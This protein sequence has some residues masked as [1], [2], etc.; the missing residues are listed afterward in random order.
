MN[1][2]IVRRFIISGKVQGVF[3][4]ASTRQQALSLNITGYARNLSNGGVEVF[5]A[6][7]EQAVARLHQ[8]LLQGPP[9]ARVDRVEVTEAFTETDVHAGF[10]TL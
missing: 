6:G 9:T 1:E 10:R 3:F 2:R 5:A 8:W 7:T 4:R